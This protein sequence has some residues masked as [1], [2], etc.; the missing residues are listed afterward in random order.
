[1]AKQ[2]YEEK[3]TDPDLREKIKEEIKASDKGGR[4][5]QWSARKSQLLTQ[6]YEKRG[7][8]YRGDKDESQ[9][10]LE[11]WT[12]EEW[13]TQEGEARARDGE[14]T[15]RYLPKEAWENMSEGEK[16]ETERK[17]R[18]SSKEGEQYVANTEEAKKARKESRSLPLKNYD[19]L[20]AEEVEKKI[21]G[22][23]QKEIRE[24][25]DYEKDHKNRKTLM[26][27]LDR[28]L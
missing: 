6:E 1:M 28:K 2:D 25:R 8:G 19:N 15:A 21:K 5:G 20:N 26:E 12:D 14:E 3:Y 23:S 22:L 11:K 10:D 18:E 9:K 4:P 13:Q 24:L 27:S 7:G 16:R 17:K